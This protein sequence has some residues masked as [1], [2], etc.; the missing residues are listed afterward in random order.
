MPLYK[1]DW[2][3]LTV[4]MFSFSAHF[5]SFHTCAA[6]IISLM[7]TMPSTITITHS[8][9]EN[10]SCSC[11]S[12]KTNSLMRAYSIL[13]PQPETPILTPVDVH[14]T[15]ICRGHILGQNFV[16]SDCGRGPL[17]DEDHSGSRPHSF[18]GL[19]LMRSGRAPE[20][21]RSDP[22]VAGS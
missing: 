21:F 6:I 1:G 17:Q 18:P 4:Q 7:N 9:P 14:A 10:F 13:S 15:N 22:V 8:G 20:W 16:S 2:K 11:F 12:T 5:S 19:Y 3:V